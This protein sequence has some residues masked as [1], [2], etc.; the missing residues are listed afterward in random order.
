MVDANTPVTENMNVYAVYQ[1]IPKTE[2]VAI[3]FFIDGT[4]VSEPIEVIKGEALGANIPSVP[5]KRGYSFKGW[6]TGENGTGTEVTGSTIAETDMSIF[7]FYEKNTGTEP[8]PQPDPDPE[9]PRYLIKAGIALKAGTLVKTEQELKLQAVQLQKQI[10]QFL[11]FMKKIQVQNQ[12][13]SQIQTQNFL[14]QQK[15]LPIAAYT[16]ISL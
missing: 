3:T 8:D 4:A 12:T 5:D 6:Y 13:H 11:H 10:C 14:L 2:K 9:L 15:Q 16:G 7:A 1:E